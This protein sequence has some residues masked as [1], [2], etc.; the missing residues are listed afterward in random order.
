MEEVMHPLRRAALDLAESNAGVLSRAQGRAVG[1]SDQMIDG[2]LDDGLFIVVATGVY[3]VRGVPQTEKMAIAAALLATGGTAS[4]V[5]ASRQLQLRAPLS[6]V[7]LHATVDGATSHRRT[8]RI[9]V[10]TD[11]QSFHP[12]RVHRYARLAEPSIVVDGVRCTD[13]ART[14]IDIARWLQPDDPEDAF[15]R[16]RHLGLVSTE[17]LAGRFALIG[18]RGRPGTPKLRKLLEQATP[19]PLESKL[20]G[21]AWRMVRASTLPNPVRQLR[22]DVAPRRW[23]RLDFAWPGLKV[24][25][26]TEGFEWHGTRARWKQDR[27]R[28]AALERVGW[29]IV[30][31]DW[32]DV[33]ERSSVTLDRI[34]MALAERRAWMRSA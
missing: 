32:D 19:N 9:A 28:T 22:V 6:A 29:R 14:L 3:R 27:I 12:V 20:E 17:T 16:A 31:A 10:E 7:P 4:H 25:F 18:G 11:D 5:T 23:H 13:A 8:V 2:C 33:V 34:A 26:E 15:E 30:N 24:A 21:R 1:L